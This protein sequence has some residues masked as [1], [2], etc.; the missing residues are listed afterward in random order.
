MC[1]SD[2]AYLVA[3][4]GRREYLGIEISEDYCGIAEERLDGSFVLESA[5]DN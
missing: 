1:G 2:G 5:P 3:K 4:I